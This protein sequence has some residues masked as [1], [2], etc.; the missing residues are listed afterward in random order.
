MVPSLLLALF[1]DGPDFVGFDTSH[2]QQPDGESVFHR[3]DSEQQS[4]GIDQ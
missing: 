2:A 1:E 4:R 3:H